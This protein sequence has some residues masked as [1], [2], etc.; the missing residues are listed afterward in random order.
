[1][2]RF[3]AQSRFLRDEYSSN[4]SHRGA[5]RA[6][7]GPSSDRRNTPPWLL[8]PSWEIIRPRGSAKIVISKLPARARRPTLSN[9]GAREPSPARYRILRAGQLR[10]NCCDNE[11][12]A[13]PHLR[14]G[15]S[16]KYTALLMPPYVGGQ[17]PCDL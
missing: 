8:M 5:I 3:S 7:R 12:R 15:P 14:A 1:M 16:A 17:L 11:E 2:G 9:I 13:V 10:I 4:G 6:P